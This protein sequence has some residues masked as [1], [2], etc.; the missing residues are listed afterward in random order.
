M[1]DCRR[2]RPQR[3]RRES[4][5]PWKWAARGLAAALAWDHGDVARSASLAQGLASAEE[6]PALAWASLVQ[7]AAASTADKRPARLVTE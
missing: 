3:H 6:L 1:A 7:A 4:W 2:A 5:Y